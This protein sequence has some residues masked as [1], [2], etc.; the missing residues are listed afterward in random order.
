M[1]LAHRDIMHLYTGAM[2]SNLTVEQYLNGIEQ[3]STNHKGVSSKFLTI[4]VGKE[5]TTPQIC[6]PLLLPSK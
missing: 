5:Q 2:M 4:I 3:Y 1:P 6:L